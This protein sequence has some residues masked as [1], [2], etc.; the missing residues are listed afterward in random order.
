MERTLEKLCVKKCLSALL[1][2]YAIEDLDQL[3]LVV[4]EML[5]SEGL[6]FTAPL[7]RELILEINL[8]HPV[9]PE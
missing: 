5:V 6:S 3:V 9:H 8:E 7:V 4:T 2:Q 1:L